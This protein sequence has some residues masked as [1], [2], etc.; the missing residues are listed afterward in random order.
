LWLGEWSYPHMH[1]ESTLGL[2][3]RRACGIMSGVRGPVGVLSVQWRI[4]LGQREWLRLYLISAVFGG[5][6][7]DTLC[8]AVK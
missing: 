3:H 1:F 8:V 4:S 6:L 5:I 7:L 2:Y